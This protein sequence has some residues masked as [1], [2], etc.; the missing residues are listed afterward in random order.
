M[1]AVDVSN[2]TGRLTKK[3]LNAWKAADVGLVIV[4]AI[5]PPEGYPEGVTRQQVEACDAAG[6]AVDAYLWLWMTG[7]FESD[8]RHKLSL[9]D[10]LPIRQLWL[11]VEDTSGGDSHMRVIR[12]RRALEICDQW[13]IDHGGATVRTG[14]NGEG[15]RM[16]HPT[17]VYSGRWYWPVYMQNTNEFADRELW[18]ANYDDNPDASANFRPYG[19]WRAARIKQYRG[20]SELAGQGGIDMNVLSVAEEAELEDDVVIPDDYVSK[21]DLHDNHDVE[22]LIANFEGIIDSVLHDRDAYLSKLESI[23]GVLDA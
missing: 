10:G 3:T 15:M 12:T 4:Q 13:V 1:L 20:T 18:D 21:F 6:L 19:G 11:D 23:R 22:G 2:Y 8:I 16:L 17:G 14:L 9:L 7:D 5:D